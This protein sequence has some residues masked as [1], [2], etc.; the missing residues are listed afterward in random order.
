MLV[1]KYTGSTAD[2]L[3]ET[4]VAVERMLKLKRS[5][6]TARAPLP[7]PDIDT[8]E[9]DAYQPLDWLWKREEDDIESCRLFNMLMEDFPSKIPPEIAIL[10]Y[11]NMFA[12][13]FR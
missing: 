1:F 13:V 9:P 10:V 4:L 5:N 7:Y 3:C 6:L 12:Y 2:L 8:Y 11:Y